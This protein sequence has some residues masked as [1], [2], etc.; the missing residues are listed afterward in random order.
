ML[1]VEEAKAEIL[2]NAEIAADTEEVV[3]LYAAG[4]ILAEDVV[5]QIRVPPL[6][7]SQMDGYAVR[8]DDFANG[9]RVFKIFERIYAGHVGNPLPPGQCSR[10]FT[11]APIPEGADSVIPQEEA[12]ERPDG[13]VEFK[14]PPKKRGGWIRLAG[15]DINSGDIVLRKGDRLTPPAHGVVASVCITNLKVYRQIIVA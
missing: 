2:K 12:V 7:N 8:F 11:G 4:R 3:T 14:T 6:D 9:A 1:T 15:C 13:F 10:I 5:S